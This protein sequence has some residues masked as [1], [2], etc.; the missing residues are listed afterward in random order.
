MGR[1]KTTLTK[2]TALKLFNS[3]RSLFTKDF[4]QNKV[5]VSEL[6]D[7]SS[8]K[9]RNIVAGYLARLVKQDS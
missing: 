5:K 1:I 8:K 7:I 9:I 6:T 4:D 3:H 2:R